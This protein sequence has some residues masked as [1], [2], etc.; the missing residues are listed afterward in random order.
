MPAL[1]NRSIGDY[2]LVAFLGAGGMGEVYRAEHHHLGRT[3]AVK[4]LTNTDPQASHAA[5]F[6]NEAR[7]HA[8]LQHENIARLY[9]YGEVDGKPCLIMEYVEGP[10]L[11]D[12]IASSGGLPVPEA[13]RLFR[14]V[15]EA[16]RYMHEQGIVH[17]DL[18]PGNIKVTPAGQVKLLD[19]GI[20][21]GAATPRLTRTGNIV[22]TVHCLAP[23][24]IR[25]QEADA[26]SDIWALG[27]VLYE[28]VSG[29]VPFEATN[30]LDLYE[31]ISKASFLPP[32]T[33]KPGVPRGV[34]KVIQ[35][36]LK[37]NPADRYASAEDLLK[38]LTRYAGTGAREAG[39]L[40]RDRAGVW[41]RSWHSALRLG[42]NGVRQK[43]S[44]PS[45]ITNTLATWWWAIPAG[46]AVL[47][48]LVMLAWPRGATEVPPP[49]PEDAG[50]TVAVRIDLPEGTAQVYQPD[51]VLVSQTPYLVR[52]MPGTRLQLVLRREGYQDKPIEIE[53]SDRYEDR[54]REYLF[55]MEK[56]RR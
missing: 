47:L 55:S 51:G 21:K 20:S 4:V 11:S 13:I 49:P 26:R 50:A 28:M 6:R 2:R 46:L 52:A 48:L 3:V 7:L 39:L 37:K 41:L 45:A 32:S 12:L 43:H 33:L 42:G 15:V 25:G 53:F 40:L 34:E 56:I 27:V 22:G 10:M 38:A 16:V 29:Q 24:Q 8:R 35:R 19:F 18:K 23:E 36:C 54:V 9:E 14:E 30:V 5:R 44:E 31:R 17:R 1:L